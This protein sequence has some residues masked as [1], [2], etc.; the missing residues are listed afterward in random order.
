[1]HVRD[2]LTMIELT[3]L[4]SDSVTSPDDA[5]FPRGERSLQEAGPTSGGFDEARSAASTLLPAEV[6]LGQPLAP[7]FLWMP[8][9]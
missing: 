5:F 1:M 9:S 4:R 3:W 6:R 2:G 7:H 8:S